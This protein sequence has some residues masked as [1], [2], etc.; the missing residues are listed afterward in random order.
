M[1]SL[2]YPYQWFFFLSTYMYNLIYIMQMGFCLCPAIT[3]SFFK[4]IGW[5]LAC[6]SVLMWRRSRRSQKTEKIRSIREKP[7][8]LPSSLH[9]KAIFFN[10]KRMAQKWMN[11]ILPNFLSPCSH[12]MGWFS[13]KF[14]LATFSGLWENEIF[15][16]KVTA[17]SVG[18][19]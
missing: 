12:V 13:T 10:G 11:R 8:I 14:F 4:L 18:R 6:W 19:W 5:K 3:L 15:V 17:T 16:Q 9:N 2:W 7:D 1:Q